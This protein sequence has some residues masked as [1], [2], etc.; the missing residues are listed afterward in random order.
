MR[1]KA[2]RQLEAIIRDTLPEL[3][4]LSV[5]DGL[6]QALRGDLV[7]RANVQ[8]KTVFIAAMLSRKASG[9]RLQGTLARLWLELKANEATVEIVLPIVVDEDIGESVIGKIDEFAARCMPHA[10]FGVIGAGSR[11]L[12]IQGLRVENEIAGVGVRTQTPRM[13]RSRLF[14]D[15]D[16]WILKI[17]L[18]ARLRQSIVEEGPPKSTW[19]PKDARALS[20]FAAVAYE[21]AR[22]F[23]DAYAERGFLIRNPAP[24]RLLNVQALLTSWL[25]DE[26]GWTQEQ[27]FARSLDGS[28][29]DLKCLKSAEFDL[30]IGG[31]QA[32]RAHGLKHA[33]NPS[34]PLLLIDAPP[35]KALQAF[36][37]VKCD[38]RDAQV[39]FRRPAHPNSVFRAAEMSDHGYKIVDP[40]Q[41]ALDVVQ[42]RQRGVEQAG[43]ILRNLV[44][45]LAL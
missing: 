7:A 29:P 35:A 28:E 25:E 33:S 37:F 9:E 40:W 38:E 18:I 8:G 12:S 22:S 24:I 30:V 1:T 44:S 32:A 6:D 11:V 21:T 16:R 15:V 34:P 4:D 31:F 26:R 19:P 23:C 13:K 41:A 14:T 36:D 20:Y 2:K 27:I 17:F 10:S 43:F 42:M 5:L 3:E 45:E 39:I